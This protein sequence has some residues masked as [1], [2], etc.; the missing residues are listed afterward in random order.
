MDQGVRVT[1]PPEFFTDSPEALWARMRLDDSGTFRVYDPN[2]EASF[3][4]KEKPD[5]P[6]H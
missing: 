2:I 5:T 4:V 6:S 1:Y 3:T